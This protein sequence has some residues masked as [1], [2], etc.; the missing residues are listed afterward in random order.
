M[1]AYTVRRLLGT[2]PLL[3]AASILTFLLIDLSGDPLADLRV[4]QP[5]FPKK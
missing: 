4:Q 5:P 2:I 3:L 1:L